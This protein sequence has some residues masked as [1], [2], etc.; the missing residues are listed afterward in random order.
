VSFNRRRLIL[1]LAAGSLVAASAAA[2]AP[3]RSPSELYVELEDESGSPLPT[4]HRRGTTFVVGEFGERYAVRIHNPTGERLEAVVSV[5]GRDVVSGSRGDYRRQRGYIVPAYG[6]IRIDGFR[7][8]L[9]VVAAFRFGDPRDSYSAR[10]GTPENVG[11]IGVAL[12]RPRLPSAQSRREVRAASKPAP[13]SRTNLGTEFGE[14]RESRVREVGF[15]RR[16]RDP[17]W[18]LTLRYDDAAGLRARG[19]EV[20]ATYDRVEPALPDPFPAS[21]FAEP[22]LPRRQR[23]CT[24]GCSVD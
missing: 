2:E 15:E 6:S 21:R 16:A 24:R 8:S 7:R 20:E 22:P 19:I 11:V 18:V 4:F 14:E 23:G 17:D 1:G 13:A 9:D 10:R 5:D 3:F 12:F